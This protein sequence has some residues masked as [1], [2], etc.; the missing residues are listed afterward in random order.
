MLTIKDRI[1]LAS[2]GAASGFILSLA[3]VLLIRKNV[4]LLAANWQ[5][6]AFYLLVTAAGAS[7]G[8]A[9]FNLRAGAVE[10]K[11]QRAIVWLTVIFY[12]LYVACATLCPK[13]HFGDLNLPWWRT[14]GLI[15]TSLGAMIRVWAIATLGTLHSGFVTIQEKHSL[16]RTGLYKHL[17]HPSYLGGLIFLAGVPMVFGSWFPLLALPGAYIL[18]RWRIED[19]ERL[20]AEQFGAEFDEYKSQTWR[21]IPHV[22]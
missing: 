1:I 3:P 13:I 16:I 18:V 9:G 17:R 12:V 2:S 19:E 22:Y 20:L 14:M 8:A 7:G 21:L 10:I 15:I 5:E 11:S 6:L 4:H